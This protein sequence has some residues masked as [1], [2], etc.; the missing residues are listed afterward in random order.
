MRKRWKKLLRHVSF[1][2]GGALAGLAY[3]LLAGCSTG[4]CVITSSPWISM[5]HMGLV[6]ALLSGITRTECE[7]KCN[8]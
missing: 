3:Y 1:I 2:A 7:D 4:G 5:A 6:G 8:M